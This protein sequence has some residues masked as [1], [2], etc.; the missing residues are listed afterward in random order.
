VIAA[1]VAAAIALSPADSFT[2]VTLAVTAAPVARRHHPFTVT[3]VVRADAGVLDTRTAPLRIRVKLASECGGSFPYTAGPVLLD[4]ELHPQ[5]ATGRPYEAAATGA[6]KPR[7]YGVQTVCVFLEEEGDDRQ[8]ATDTAT[9]VDVSKLCTERA[10]AY[11]RART[12]TRRRAARAA[13]G[14]GVPL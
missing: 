2:P 1:F 8:F 10:A 4:R 12:R 3:V 14:P 6:G 7:S 11:D 5:P 9:T 13:C